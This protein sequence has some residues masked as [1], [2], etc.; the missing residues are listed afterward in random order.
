MTRMQFNFFGRSTAHQPRLAGFH[1]LQEGVVLLLESEERFHF[2][3]QE[4]S[5]AWDHGWGLCSWGRG[6]DGRCPSCL[7]LER[8][9]ASCPWSLYY[10]WS[11]LVYHG[12]SLGLSSQEHQVEESRLGIGEHSDFNLGMISNRT[13]NQPLPTCRCRNRY[14]YFETD[15]Y[16]TYKQSNNE[17]CFEYVESEAQINA[18]HQKSNF[19][20]NISSNLNF[21]DRFREQ[22]SAILRASTFY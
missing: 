10:K 1:A 2:L 21:N 15:K 5:R 3:R 14:K 6:W 7:Y 16:I 8:L 17:K 13:P 12:G 20:I 4:G 22:H 9:S 18:S 11:R 19:S